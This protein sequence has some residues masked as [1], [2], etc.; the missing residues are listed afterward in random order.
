MTE[1]KVSAE[2][3]V[4]PGNGHELDWYGRKAGPRLRGRPPRRRLGLATAAEALGAREPRP[5]LVAMADGR[6]AGRR[7]PLRRARPM[8]RPGGPATGAARPTAP[9]GAG[10]VV[11]HLR[12]AGRN[13]GDPATGR[14]N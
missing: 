14:G 13:C 7:P 9:P 1:G 12:V 5:L 8:A 10:H 11:G 3:A 4:T 2:H 6:R